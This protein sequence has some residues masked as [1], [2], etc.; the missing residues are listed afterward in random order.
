MLEPRYRHV[1]FDL[2][3]TIYDSLESNTRALYDLLEKEKPNHGESVASLYRFAA[4]PARQ[5]LITLG[6][7]DTDFE[8]LIQIWCDNIIVYAHSVKPFA[9]MMAVIAYLKELGCHMSIITSRDRKSASLIG[10]IA[11][12]MPP[13]LTPYFD[14]A[15]CCDDVEHPKPHPDSILEYMR[16][17][18]AQ[19]EDIIYIG[20]TLEDYQCAK[21]AGVDFGLAIWGSH[22][23]SALKCAHYF[24]SPWDIVN[25]LST[26][27]CRSEMWFNWAREIQAIGQIGL[28]YTRDKFDKERFERLRE[29]ALEIMQAHLDVPQE[30]LLKSFVFDEQYPTPK[31]DTRGAVFNDEGKILMVKE[32]LSGKWNLPGGWC[33]ADETIFSNTVKEVLEEAGMQVH[34]LKL[35]AL[36]DRNRHNPPPMPYGVLKAFVLCQIGAQHF[37]ALSDETSDCGFFSLDE[38]KQLDLRTGTTTYEQLKLC[39]AAHASPNWIPI[40]E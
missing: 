10:A 25:V 38:I 11:S 18:G 19:R 28:T 23:R 34:P 5:T 17:T 1:L 9:G 35:I 3:G 22:L 40:V 37:V 27:P 8:R 24:V 31:L 20:D 26:K 32:S 12:P 2:D 16:R 13:E 39:F 15:I 29:I 6:F 36:V 30:K 7:S 33:D 4:T 21:D 14:M